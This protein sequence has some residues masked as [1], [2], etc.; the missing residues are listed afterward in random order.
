MVGSK[1]G[2]ERKTMER[3][4]FLVLAKLGKAVVKLVVAAAV[5]LLVLLALNTFVSLENSILKVVLDLL[6][7]ASV[8]AL[9][10]FA[11]DRQ[12]MRRLF[13]L[14]FERLDAKG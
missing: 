7:G 6:L 14:L 13:G 2:W 1:G 10:L 9:A 12:L 5:M 8:Y 11:I 4:K 3:G